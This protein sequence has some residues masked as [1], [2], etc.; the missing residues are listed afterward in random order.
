MNIK[1]IGNLLAYITTEIPN[2]SVRKMIKLVYLIDEQSV[3]K[4]NIPVTWLT[5]FVWEKGP[6]APCIYEIKEN[7]KNLFS[8]YVDV[9]RD[10]HDKMVITAL[11]T[12]EK[13]SLSF[14]ENELKLIDNILL[15]YG[16][17]SADALS[18][19]THKKNSLWSLA[20]LKFKPDFVANKGKTDIAIDLRE[21]LTTEEEKLEIYDDAYEVAML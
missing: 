19:H 9:T 20:K 21:L 5:Y 12:K 8:E 13:A 18:E 16:N 1:K 3:S 17:R 6:V 15:E 14:S 10:E 7:D 11:K 2:I 4:R